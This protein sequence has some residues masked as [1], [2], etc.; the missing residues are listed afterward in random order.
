MKRAL[1]KS[2]ALSVLSFAAPLAVQA[3]V[4]VPI[5]EPLAADGTQL[6]TEL[7]ISNFDTTERPYAAKFLAAGSDGVASDMRSSLASLRAEEAHFLDKVAPRG[8]SGLLVVDAAPGMMVDAWVQTKSSRGTTYMTGVPVITEGLRVAAGSVSYLNGLGRDTGLDLATLALINLGQ[9]AA[10]CQVEFLRADGSPLGGAQTVDLPAVSLRKFDD[11]LGLRAE[12]E[13]SSA[14]VSCDQT[15]YAFAQTLN[16]ET[17]QVSFVTPDNAAA[18]AK[19]RPTKADPIGSIIFERTGLFHSPTT[20]N[21]KGI[22]RVPVPGALQLG[23]I[24]VEMDFK[25]GPWNKRQV[26]GNHG[27]LYLHRGIFRGNT[28][29][30]INVMGPKKNLFRI[31]QNLE[32]PARGSTNAKA[33]FPWVKDQLYGF[34]FEEVTANKNITTTLLGT[35]GTVLRNLKTN[36]TARTIRVEASG[37]VAEFSHKNGQHLPEV[38]TPPGWEYRNFRVVMVPKK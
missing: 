16:R 15:F 36:G 22:I 13:A 19:A 3:Q 23:Q 8:E 10:V 32:L 20:A 30:N 31:N 21:P 5:I 37:L 2:L 1:V 28:I 27:M 34:R 29:V 17:T 4:F 7:W 11:S 6:K 14:Q 33:S 12:S 25:V 24:I 26:S 38:S 9:G 35:G 18:P